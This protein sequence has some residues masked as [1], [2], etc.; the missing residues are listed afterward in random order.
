MT[1]IDVISTVLMFKQNSMLT[2]VYI[3]AELIKETL[4]SNITVFCMHMTVTYYKKF[5]V[6]ISNLICKYLYKRINF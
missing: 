4:F 1:T 2:N 3:V 6:K 5:P